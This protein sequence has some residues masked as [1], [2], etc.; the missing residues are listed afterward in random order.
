[1][2]KLEH[3]QHIVLFEFIRGVKE[4]E[5]ARNICGLYGDNAIGES[6]A[7]KCFSCF[8]EDCF[9]ISDT[10]RSGKPSRFDED[11]LNTLIHN[12]PC[13]CT[14]EQAT[15]MNCNHST[16][17]RYFHSVSNVK[18]SGVCAPH[19]L[20]QNHKNQQVYICA[21]LLARHR[22][23]REQHRPFLS[24]IVTGDEECCL[25]AKI[26]KRKEWLN[27]SKRRICRKCSNFCI[28]HSIF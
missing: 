26:R 3:L 19:D 24:C 17:V 27:P 18:K 16:I 1:M 9:D 2:E 28:W 6:T 10:P 25:Y 7:R 5:A 20:S 14:R 8:K 11:H 21:S 22:L 13:Q 12:D 4:T 15:V 23:A